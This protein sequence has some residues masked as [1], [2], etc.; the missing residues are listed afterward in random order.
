[1]LEVLMGH[2]I[3]HKRIA[4]LGPYQNLHFDPRQL[5]HYLELCQPLRSDNLLA[6]IQKAIISDKKYTL[7]TLDDGFADFQGDVLPILEA[8]AMP[9]IMFLT[10]GFID[11]E[12]LPY[13]IELADIIQAVDR[14]QMDSHRSYEFNSNGDRQAFYNEIR[15]QLKYESEAVRREYLTRLKDLHHLD[16][17]VHTRGLFLSWDDVLMLDKHPLVSLGAHSVTH[18]SLKRISWLSAYN[19]IR[20]SKRTIESIVGHQI[21]FFSYPYG[22]HSFLVR[23]MV[24]FCGFRYGFTTKPEIASP[25]NANRIAIPRIDLHLVDG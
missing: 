24:Q 21:P 3:A 7:L 19:E 13:E 12:M 10:T 17:R 18:P 11:G 1:M 9:C 15:L 16:N 5:R 8:F 4:S 22:D 6:S 20:Q 14:I 23:L 2:R 25:L